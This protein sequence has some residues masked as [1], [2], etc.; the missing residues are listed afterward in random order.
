M[1]NNLSNSIQFLP[2]E[3]I[4]HQDI[5]KQIQLFYDCFDTLSTYKKNE[6]NSLQLPSL[7]DISHQDIEKQIQLF[8]DYFVALSTSKKD[9][10]S[11]LLELFVCD[12]LKA[13]FYKKL[14]HYSDLNELVNE[15]NKATERMQKNIE[16]DIDRYLRS[17]T[18]KDIH[19]LL[20]SIRNIIK[21]FV[22]TV[23][24]KT[25]KIK[26]NKSDTT[27]KIQNDFYFLLSKLLKRNLIDRTIPSFFLGMEEGNHI[28]IYE[29]LLQHI[30][31]FLSELGVYTLK[32]ETGQKIDFEICEGVISDNNKTSSYESRETIK[33]IRQ[34]PYLFDDKHIVAEGKVVVW[35]YSND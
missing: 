11:R 15:L 31:L 3:D 6:H 25:G 12:Q 26:P 28:E 5:E 10:H 21:E 13:P 35:R 9:D 27:E 19:K 30:N 8:H 14:K 2:L 34:F 17:L 18:I 1:N 29:G 16:E 23:K 20:Y 32:I 4:S 22:T 7:E 33:E 24:F